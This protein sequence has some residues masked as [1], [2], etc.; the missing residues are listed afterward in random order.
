M[1]FNRIDIFEGNDVDKQMH[2]K[3]LIFFT[4]GFS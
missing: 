1:Y 3:S 4:I 2:Q